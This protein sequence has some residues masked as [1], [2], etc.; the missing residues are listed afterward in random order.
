MDVRIAGDDM[1]NADCSAPALSDLYGR[2]ERQHWHAQEVDFAR[3]R[4]DWLALTDHERWQWYWLAGFSHFRRSETHGLVCLATL[5]PCLRRPDQQL[6]LG[7]QI[8]D[9]SRHALFFERFHREVLDAA[10][11]GARQGQSGISAAY[12]ALFIDCAAALAR[13]A[14]NEPSPQN[15]AAAVL[16]IFI[17]L[18]GAL[19]LASFSV[20]R[21]LLSRVGLFPG[22]LL[23]MTHAHRDEVRHAQ[24]GVAL[25]Q[26][27]LDRE[28][29]AR[30]AAAAQLE[31]A[32]PLF[33]EVLNPRPERKA[34][35]ESLGLNPYERRE[36]AFAHLQR[37]LRALDL[38][39][40]LVAPWLDGA[41]S[42]DNHQTARGYE[43]ESA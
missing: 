37:H 2:W 35:L 15:L 10:V 43:R 39:A 14:A 29:S 8:A 1:A 27:I 38:D 13:K 26:D 11:P 34:I 6:V 42:R 3:D 17:V 32:L 33:S 4:R 12:Q 20:I 9:E 30:G 23:G 22:L 36:R 31:A 18:E 7:T 19:A 16:H 28:P 40:G 25:L 41:R 24:L 21:R 5:L